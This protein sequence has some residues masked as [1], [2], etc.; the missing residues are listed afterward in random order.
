MIR[1]ALIG[2]GAERARTE[3]TKHGFAAAA[4]EQ[5]NPL[6]T[7]VL[8]VFPDA[9]PYD[10]ERWRRVASIL[11]AR[12]VN[13]DAIAIAAETGALA[14]VLEGDHARLVGAI[15]ETAALA[16]QPTIL[17]DA[18]RE[19]LRKVFDLSPNY[20]CVADEHGRFVLAN[21]AFADF[22]GMTIED[23]LARP[24]ASVLAPHEVEQASSENREVIETRRSRVSERDVT[25]RSGAKRRL[26]I[27]KRPLIMDD[28]TVLVMLVASDVTRRFRIETELENTNDF[29]KNILETITDAVFALDLSGKFTLVNHRLVELTG[30]EEHALLAAPFVKIFAEKTAPEAKRQLA[31]LFNGPTERHFE[32]RIVHPD[33]TER[34]VACSLLPLVRQGTFVGIVG[35]AENVTERRVAERRIEHLAYH[36][37]LT[38]LPNR[39]LLND[40]LAVA[41]SQAMRDR[42]SVAVLFLDLDRFKSIN[43]TLGHRIGDLLLQELGARLRACMRQGDTVARMGGDEFVFVIPGLVRMDEAIVI[44]EK[45]LETVR[46]PFFLDGRELVVTACVGLSYYPEHALDGDTL[47]RQADVA[48]FE[49]KNRGR[50]TWCAYDSSM[51]LRSYERFELE[52]D[53]RRALRDDEFQLY[54][55][56]IVDIHTGDI[57]ALEALLRWEHPVRGLLSPEDFIELAEDTGLIE[58]L[59]EW[60]LFEA[61]RQ[62]GEWQRA[63]LDPVVTAV[64]VSAKQFE[65]PIVETVR[66]A[67]CAARLEPQYLTLELTESVLVQSVSSP[68]AISELKALGVEIAIDDFG[69]GYSSL[70][71]LERFPIDVIKID[72]TFMPVETSRPQSGFIAGAIISLAHGMGIRVVAEGIETAA[73]ADFLLSRGCT[74][75]QG[76]LYAPAMPATEIERLLRGDVGDRILA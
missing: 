31:E 5:S 16:N 62:A 63:G 10:L 48:L 68:D 57:L 72:R 47:T 36:D 18:E 49:C 14:I 4:L 42:R 51:S 46:Q 13:G 64:N 67:L 12:Q 20:V 70:S 27:I 34:I 76:H 32:G 15:E 58:R 69:T 71:Y 17:A 61:T 65:G 54:Y 6:E 28:G 52:H 56:P 59:G 11:V 38:N 45:I 43:D 55:Q 23:L 44:T 9:P 39:R 30:L 7:D 22:Y 3:L 60:A 25:D 1:I 24:L 21:Q 8:V 73:Q 40:R 37:P 26:S 2:S 33:G 19:L 50:D 29:L 53:L 35:T 75:G 41:L 66:A 74:V